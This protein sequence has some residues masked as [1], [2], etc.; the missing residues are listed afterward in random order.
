M[1]TITLYATLLAAA[2]LSSAVVS[3]AE[4]H[5]AS[6]GTVANPGTVEKPV[7]TLQAAQQLVRSQ[8]A[9][10][11]R[12]PVTVII[13]GGTYY[14]DAP[15]ALT[16]EDSGTAACPITWRAVAGEKVVLSGGVRIT[17]KWTQGSDGIWSV[18]IP[19]V[20]DDWNF[21]QLFVNGQ[22]AIRARYPNVDA[23]HSFLYAKGGG[24]D[25]VMIEPKSTKTSWGAARDVQINIV[26][27]WLFF[28][29]WNTV[30]AVNPET[31]R[32]DI[33]DSERHGKIEAG[34][35]FWIEG[36]KEE[37][38]QPR[39]WF[40]DRAEGRLYYLPELGAD[41]NTLNIVAPRL[42]VIVSAKGEVEKKTHVEYVNFSDLEFRHTTFTLGHI[43]ARVHTDAAIRLENASDCRIENCHIENI[44]GYAFWL[45]LD[46]RRNVIDRNTVLD[47]GGGGVLF[48]GARFSYMD[49]SKLFTPGAVAATVFPILNRVTRN[50]VKNCGKI[51]YY[52][53]GA[54]LDSRPACMTMEPGN[55][56]AHN[57][58]SDLSRNGIFAFRN[59][60]G[61][62]VEYN[63]IH[64]AMQTTIDGACIH[65]ATMSHL[66]APNFILNNWLY[67]IWGYRQKPDGKPLRSKLANGIFLDW[68]TS[69]TT[70]KDNYVYN[71]G[72]EPIK[73]IWENWGIKIEGNSS[74]ATR[75]I[76]PFADEVGPQ[77]I[78]TNAIDLESNRLTGS[79]IHYSD[80]KRVTRTGEWE[81]TTLRSQGGLFTFD[82]LKVAQGK[83]AEISYALPIAEDGTYQISLLYLPDMANATDALIRIQ[84]A[85]G[86]A[87]V[88]WN[89]QTGPQRG[90]AV[91]VGS[92]HFKAGK[93]ATVTISSEGAT[94]TVVA[95]SVAFV[96][97]KAAAGPA[98]G[99]RPNVIVI[100]ADDLGCGDMSLY[101]GWI[102]T[103]RIEQ[104]A[105]EGVR[106]TD[107]HSNSSV[108]SPT[109]AALLTG[110]YHQR[111]GIIDVIASHLDTPGLEATELTIPRLM[112]QHGYKTA[113]F[114]KWHLGDEARHNPIHHGF[115]EFVGFLPGGSDY[116]KHA[117]WLD[118]TEVKDQKGYS[119]DIIT[120][121][122]LDFIK[123]NTANPFFLYVAHQAVHNPYQTLADTPENRPKTMPLGGERALASYQIMLQ[124]LDKSVGRILDTLKEQGLEENTLVFFFS[125]N[126]DVGKNMKSRLYRGG[127]FSNY[128]G[129][130]R[131]PAVARWPGHIKG[132]WTSDELTVGMDLL[133]TIADLAG[134]SIPAQRKFDGISIKDHLLKQTDLPD[135][136]VFFGY[137]PKLGTA[138]RDGHWKMLTK[139]ETVELYDLSKDMKETTNIAE[140][141]PQ[142]AEEMK[143]AIE[144]WKLEVTP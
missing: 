85:N 87:Q 83:R 71:A 114:G 19:S 139:G 40:L 90:F 136:R 99:A 11:L 143:A 24:I 44:G 26:P 120:D 92:Y 119:T 80:S 115:D 6:N 38:D 98:A 131:V 137:E 105:R 16:A 93:S 5:I 36:V 82:Q 7:A 55:L 3:G 112:K 50:T 126:G 56:I 103:P 33:A 18:A 123:R 51:R 35:W 79:V 63:L 125:D 23:P 14:L 46:S 64:D 13:H 49:D 102:K 65:F 129:G 15:L 77:G 130:H 48:T 52:G 61:N 60:G 12:E 138:M 54:H 1:H 41:P 43:E 135:R 75:I 91:A 97:A 34:N 30:T 96:K 78:A 132:D 88:R 109:R 95:D 128:E 27:H 66:N 117:S 59:Q 108:C 22:R 28:N 118:G 76:P 86:V 133:P 21:R 140:K 68:D 74:S 73:A 144:I 110:R 9:K 72:G 142:R 62:I 2:V 127:K 39:E 113:L 89:L 20:K 100:L 25:H 58:F 122:S 37:L 111:V 29:Q 106:F 121:R 84:H 57:E 124:E 94:G 141:H 116:H 42:N 70:V 69:N 53:G 104:M 31:G 8:I 47:S 81:K 107:F 10:G 45:H 67:D 134:I 101:N 32:I 17:G 4:I